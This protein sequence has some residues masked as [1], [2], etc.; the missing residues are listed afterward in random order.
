[1]KDEADENNFTS[2]GGVMMRRMPTPLRRRFLQ[3]H[4]SLEVDLGDPIIHHA[5]YIKTCFA[6]D[7]EASEYVEKQIRPD[8]SP[9]PSQ[10]SLLT[11]FAYK[12]FF[13]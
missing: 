4:R 12:C 10:R 1:M 6:L 11:L 7:Y 5:G 13:R 3:R 9:M 8:A 2:K